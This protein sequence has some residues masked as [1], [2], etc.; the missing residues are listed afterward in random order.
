MES[1]WIAPIIA[2][3]LGLA[4]GWLWR[5]AGERKRRVREWVRRADED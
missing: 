2:Y 3:V 1:W 5:C 4:H